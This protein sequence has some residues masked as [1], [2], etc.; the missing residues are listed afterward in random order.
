MSVN[1]GLSSVLLTIFPNLSLIAILTRIDNVTTSRF[2]E[3]E[4]LPSIGVLIA[5]MLNLMTCNILVSY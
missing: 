1:A 4:F 5:Y 3:S 2:K